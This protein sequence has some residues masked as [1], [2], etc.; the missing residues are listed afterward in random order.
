[1]ALPRLYHKS[2]YE[3]KG[4]LNC[5][6]KL[7]HSV[8]DLSVFPTPCVHHCWGCHL[9]GLIHRIPNTNAQTSTVIC[10]WNAWVYCC[11]KCWPNSPHMPLMNGKA[12]AK[13]QTKCAVLSGAMVKEFIKASLR[14]W[15]LRENKHC[16]DVERHEYK[17]CAD[18]R[19]NKVHSIRARCGRYLMI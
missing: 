3:H 2:R 6:S 7:I 13:S 8:R 4:I 9:S 10:R 17:E 5:K 11:A 12:K 14:A 19:K 18:V 15:S 16:Y 1:M